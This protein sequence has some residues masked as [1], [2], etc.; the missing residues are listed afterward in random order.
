MPMCV[1][2]KGTQRFDTLKRPLT[3][4]CACC[5]NI[6]I[7]ISVD[8]PLCNQKTSAIT[9]IRYMAY[10]S[11]FGEG[12]RPVLPERVIKAAYGTLT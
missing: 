9:N 2:T 8:N 5:P 12:L 7:C 4:Q 1:N 6:V 10:A 3:V 11:D